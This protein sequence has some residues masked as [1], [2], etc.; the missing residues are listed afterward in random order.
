MP[1]RKNLAKKR[2][3]KDGF[4]ISPSRRLRVGDLVI[5]A[6]SRTEIFLDGIPRRNIAIENVKA[7]PLSFESDPAQI[8]EQ[9]SRE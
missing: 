5:S 3:R 8:D 2:R 7:V 9:S 1:S 6:D 4:T